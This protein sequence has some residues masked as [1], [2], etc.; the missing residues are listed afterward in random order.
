VVSN[1]DPGRLADG[2]AAMAVMAWLLAELPEP[3]PRVEGGR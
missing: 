3:L 2:T 1:V